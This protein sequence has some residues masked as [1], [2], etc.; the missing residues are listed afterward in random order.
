METLRLF[1]LRLANFVFA[2]VGIVAW[3]SY[4]V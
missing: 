4:R 3:N 1:F 2:I